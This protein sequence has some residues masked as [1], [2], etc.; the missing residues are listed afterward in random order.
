MVVTLAGD[1]SYGLMRELNRIVSDFTKEHGDL[2]I[3]QFDA[4]S[5]VKLSSIKEALNSLPFLASKKLVILR[6]VHKNKD[7]SEAIEG[8]ISDIPESTDLVIVENDPD[9]RQSIYK[10]LKK[11]TD[12]RE[13]SELKDYDLSN[14]LALEAK[15]RG[16][17]LSSSDASYLIERVGINQERLSNELDKLLLYDP[18]VSRESIDLMTEETLRSTIFQ[19][20]EEAFMGKPKNAIKLYKEQRLKNQEPPRII[21]MLSWQLYVLAIIKTSRTESTNELASQSKINP[22]VLRK[23]QSLARGL[24]L[25]RLKEL[26]N[27]LL[28]IDVLSKSSKIDVDEALMNYLLKLA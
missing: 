14:W 20:L 16:A 5:D 13:F 27:E 6:D 12:F 9:K 4:E 10:Y 2:S 11:S 8:Y 24:T 28:S 25:S 18:I 7:L 21:A 22:Y 23:S 17:E 1:N 26:T 3:E 19:L 15:K